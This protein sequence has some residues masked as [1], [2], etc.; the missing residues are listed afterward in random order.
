MS[1]CWQWC[2]P[3]FTG[4]AFDRSPI[5]AMRMPP[6]R[7][8]LLS[9]RDASHRAKSPPGDGSGAAAVKAAEDFVNVRFI[10]DL[11]KGGGY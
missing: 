3:A 1:L 11:R 4:S 2:P 6:S 5:G 8:R 10:G 7:G 9:T